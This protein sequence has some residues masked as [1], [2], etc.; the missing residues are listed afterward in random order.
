MLKENYNEVLKN[1][2][3]ACQRAGRER[4]EVNLIA[5]SKTKPVSDIEVIYGEGQRAFGENRVQELTA[6]Q[7][8]LPEDIKWHL[9]GHLQTN[10][11][12]YIIDKA[13]L[14]HSVDSLHLAEVI[15]KEANKKGITAEI[16][17]EVNVAEEES[18]F[19]T[20]VEETKALIEDNA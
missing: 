12:K 17:I 11:V 9:I 13:C 10:K 8:M 20:T 5:V 7:P 6:K 15:S 16:L 3:L 4:S 2:E 19:G 18:K 14:I 1:I